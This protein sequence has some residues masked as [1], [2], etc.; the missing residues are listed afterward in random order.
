M[1]DS[2]TCSWLLPAS[3]EDQLSDT[4]PASLRHGIAGQLNANPW[5]AK[6]GRGL[7][8]RFWKRARGAWSGVERAEHLQEYVPARAMSDGRFHW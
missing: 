1:W 6:S 3:K 4:V 5:F 7:A 8:L 2:L